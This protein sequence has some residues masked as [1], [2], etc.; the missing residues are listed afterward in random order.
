MPLLEIGSPKRTATRAAIGQ[1]A[2]LLL[3]EIDSFFG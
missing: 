1:E 3:S 2:D